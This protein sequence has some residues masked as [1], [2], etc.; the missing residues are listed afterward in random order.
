[1]S[2]KSEMLIKDSY[3]PEYEQ[4]EFGK[5]SAL[6]EIALA[7]ERQYNYY[8]MGVSS[9]FLTRKLNA[10]SLTCTGYYIPSCTKMRYKGSFKP[11]SILGKNTIR[12]FE[13]ESI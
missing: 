1:M 12:A 3:D 2:I 13:F 7:K 8:L 11:T 5:L 6:R 9:S 4:W 10:R